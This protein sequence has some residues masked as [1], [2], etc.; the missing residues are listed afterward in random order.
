MVGQLLPR[1]RTGVGWI[2]GGGWGGPWL[3]GLKEGRR[4]AEVVVSE[5]AGGGGEIIEVM[6]LAAE[7]CRTDFGLQGSRDQERLVCDRRQRE[8]DRAS[9]VAEGGWDDWRA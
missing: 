5:W 3:C 7:E 8:V 1:R 2:F 6:V 9:C 4:K